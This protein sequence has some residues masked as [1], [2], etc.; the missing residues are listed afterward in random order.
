MTARV[1]SADFAGARD[2][3]LLDA[4]K[5][6][7]KPN[8]RMMPEL[9]NKVVAPSPSP[10]KPAHDMQSA[11][12]RDID[13]V[14]TSQSVLDALRQIKGHVSLSPSEQTEAVNILSNDQEG[15]H[16]TVVA[17]MGLTAGVVLGVSGF[18]LFEHFNRSREVV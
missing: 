6:T 15:S 7:G 12:T 18:K 3:A 4:M 2:E 1:N 5:K 11:M 16:K 13:Y 8:G 10:E 17:L 9:S 14:A